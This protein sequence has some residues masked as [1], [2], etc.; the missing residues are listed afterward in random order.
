MTHD[1][2]YEAGRQ[3]ALLHLLLDV[4]ERRLDA[5]SREGRPFRLG[6]LEAMWHVER[7]LEDFLSTGAPSEP[8]TASEAPA[9][10]SPL[11]DPSGPSTAPLGPS[12]GALGHG[13]AS[14]DED[15]R[16]GGRR[17]APERGRYGDWSGALADFRAAQV[18]D[19]V[20][21]PSVTQEELD[22]MDRAYA[23]ERPPVNPLVTG[24]GAK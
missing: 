3:A 23:A 5:P 16:L 14:V 21:S 4:A 19:S 11:A 17:S 8:A 7:L 20:L 6:Y 15:R 10:P 2:A 22:E 12:T 1:P 18:C 9:A 13:A 24:K